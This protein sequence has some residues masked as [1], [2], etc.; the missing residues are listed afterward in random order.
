ME[1]TLLPLQNDDVIR[2][3]CDGP[4]S[5]RQ[6]ND[7]LHTLLGPHCYRHK[8]I[9]SL[10]RS[11]AIDTSG[12]SWLMRTQKEFAEHGGKVVLYAVPPVVLDVLDFV[13]L[14][15]LLHIAP[16]EQAACDLLADP[17]SGKPRGDGA[18]GSVLRLPPR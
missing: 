3:R 12:L 11:Q 14:T 7:P 1:L 13:R 5:C 15:P 10:E 16:G 8:V 18:A 2:I 9:L 4:V 17:P 6:A